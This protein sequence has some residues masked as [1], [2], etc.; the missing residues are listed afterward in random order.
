MPENR[1]SAPLHRVHETNNRLV[2]MR[3]P[4]ILQIIPEL[5]TGGAELSTL[6]IAEAVHLAGGR[7]LVLSE[8][9]RL[10][11]PL[12][13]RGGEFVPFPAASKNPLRL[14]W[15]AGEIA[16]MIAAEGVDLVHARSRA[17]AWSALLA[18][19]RTKRPFV[20][21]YHGAYNEKGR[22]KRFY[23]SIMASGDSVIANSHYTA[24]LIRSRYGTPETRITVIHRGVDA[25]AFDPHRVAPERVAALRQSWGVQPDC[26]VILHPARL[27]GWKGQ[28]VVVAA[29]RH[30]L[31][32][33]RLGNAVFVLA[34]DSQGRESYVAGLERTI[35]EAGLGERVC[36]VGHV[37]DMPAAFA[38]ARV[39]L[40]ASTE[41]EAFGRTAA[42]AQAMGCPVIVTSIGAPQ[43]TVR[44]A[45]MAAPGEI[46]GWVVPPGDEA[47]LAATIGE[48]LGLRD[49]ERAALARRARSRVEAHY[50]HRSMQVAT[51]AVYD[52]LL[53]T[54]LEQRLKAAVGDGN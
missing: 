3:R 19:R 7:A 44:A 39:A 8:G 6:E 21:T 23:N 34:G 36:L 47:A 52:R 45:P 29:A 1:H 14:L 5:D 12:E 43:E 13:D 22:A 2:G 28:A 40:V 18:A 10:V 42:E 49:V 38:A 27:T 26:P 30:L 9:G 4:T 16:R 46:T 25:E 35:E 51:M 11:A 37:A 17:P 32:Q 53:G 54:D 48:V 24:G 50:T 41:P 31:Q 20:T 33:G 15:N